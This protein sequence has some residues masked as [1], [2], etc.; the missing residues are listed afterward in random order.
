MAWRTDV[1][2]RGP[3]SAYC[4]RRPYRL[5]RSNPGLLPGCG[6]LTL[7]HPVAGHC[8]FSRPVVV[9]CRYRHAGRHSVTDSV[10]YANRRADANADGLRDRHAVTQPIHTVTQPIHTVT[11]PIHTVAEPIQAVPDAHAEAIAHC[12]RAPER[13]AVPDHVRLAA[14]RHRR[15]A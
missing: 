5:R 2:W 3:Q 14:D 7:G 6:R 8:G 12:V 10:S 4:P 9:R 1:G 11:Q 15:L 13:P